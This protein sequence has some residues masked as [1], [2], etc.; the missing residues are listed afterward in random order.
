MSALNGTIPV[1]E[2]QCAPCPEGSECNSEMCTHCGPCQ[3]GT[4]KDSR[5]TH[6][7]RPCPPGTFNP[8][9]NSRDYAGCRSCPAG[10]GT[11]G[12]GQTHV[13]ACRC[14]ERF[15]LVTAT[16]SSGILNCN[17]C[18]LGL[19]CPDGSCSIASSLQHGSPS[20]ATSTSAINGKWIDVDGEVSLV[21]CPTGFRLMNQT[22]DHSACRVL[23]NSCV[24]IWLT[25][26]MAGSEMQHCQECPR[27]P[28][29]ACL[30][31]AFAVSY[32]AFF[33]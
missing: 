27:S 20:C 31:A 7:C 22:G 14:E 6:A 3:P 15:Y 13:S 30:N 4:Y 10:A 11:D 29:C 18:P 16:D 21:S 33:L 17:K 23:Y 24:C 25:H 12:E 9:W 19:Q 1:D 28:Y 32:L 2:Q 8:D 26:I 5:G